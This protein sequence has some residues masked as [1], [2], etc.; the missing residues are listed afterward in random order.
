MRPRFFRIATA[1]KIPV[2]TRKRLSSVILAIDRE[3]R[4]VRDARCAQ[5][6]MRIS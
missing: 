4:S 6:R 1:A 5:A 3:D 2:W